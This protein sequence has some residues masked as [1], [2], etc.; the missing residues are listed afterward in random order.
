MKLRRNDIAFLLLIYII[1]LLLRL[2]PKL[3]IDSHLLT[4]QADIWYRVAMSQYVYDFHMLPEPDLRYVAY[5]DVPMWYP[6]LTPVLLAFLSYIAKLDIPTVC[7]RVLPFIE[8]LSPLSIYFLARKMYNEHAAKIAA[9]SLA[10]TPSFIFWTGIADTQSFTFFMI[11][12]YVLIQLYQSEKREIKNVFI[13]GVLLGFNFL[14]HLSYFAAVLALLMC[15]IAIVFSDRNKAFLL[16]DLGIAIIISQ[17]IAAPW[18]LPRNL[19]WWWAKALVTSSGLYSAI[20]QIADYGYVAVLFGSLAFLWLVFS[21]HNAESRKKQMNSLLILWVLAFFLESQN[22]RILFALGK[23]ALT[24]E[25]LA[26]PLEGFRFHP[27]LAQP[28]SIAIGAMISESLRFFGDEGN[29]AKMLALIAIFLVFLFGIRIYELDAKLQNSGITMEEYRAAGWYRE[30]AGRDSRLIADYYREQMFSGVAAG[31]TVAGGMF[32]LRNVDFPYIKAPG[33]V[34]EDIY[35]I[36]NT[37]DPTFAYA[38]MRQ[39]KATHIFYSKNME[40]YG[41]LLSRYKKASQFG[42]D[43]ALDKFYD[44]RYFKLVYESG[45]TRIFEVI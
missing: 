18:W 2:Y 17:L 27:F 7:S 29:K 41:N 11:P 8:S 13:L 39:Y 6:P 43:I 25:T 44:P 15:T 45:D 30:N 24:W 37:S 42:V 31:R 10:L 34:Q 20:D 35:I 16:K 21:L 9:V 12:L 1:G 33:T 28:I 38:V 5:G 36:Y 3:Q 32:P 23:V 40:I 26:K 4:F 14:F 19:Y 22:E